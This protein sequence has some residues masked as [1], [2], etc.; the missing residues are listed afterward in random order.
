MPRI[1]F[2]ILPLLLAACAAPAPQTGLLQ[3]NADFRHGVGAG[4][5]PWT[6]E[7]F[8]RAEDTFTFAIF[9]DL[10]GGEREGVFA[11]AVEQLRLLRPEFIVNV[12]D[13]VEGAT[14]DREQLAGEW[15]VFD[16]RA[17]HARAPV[18][19]TGG[20]HDLSNPQQWELWEQ[21]YGPR[22]YH[23]LYKDTLFLVLDTEDSPLERQ[24]YIDKIR[25]EA[26]ERVDR[27]GWSV[28]PETAYGQLEER[29]T[30]RIGAA[31]AEYFRT[32]I[33][34]NPQARHT[35]VLM[36]K[37]A[38]KRPGEENF[39]VIEAALA[40]RP[41]TVFRGHDHSYQHEQRQGRDYIGL[42]TTG[43]VLLPDA[44]LVVD[45]VTLVTVSGKEVDIAN[46]RLSGIFDKTGQIPAGGETLCF[47]L[48][49]CPHQQ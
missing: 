14:R 40:G 22:Y 31:Q 41:Y 45:H 25:S 43:G 47:E 12:G 18:F 46:L 27:E 37:P 38:W 33:A 2:L 17:R 8:D 35:F 19:Y 30:G 7:D 36:H 48:S 21:R 10:T 42:G 4:P 9:A 11:V 1:L 16:E 32:V 44:G 23:F 6:H 34:A 24:R 13:L 26:M 28:M 20:N 15:K 49:H 29:K 39:A 5:K 3:E